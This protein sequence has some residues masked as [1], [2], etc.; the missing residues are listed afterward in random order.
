MKDLFNNFDQFQ[1]CYM[2]T[3]HANLLGALSCSVCNPTGYKDHTDL[4]A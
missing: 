1:P 3:D 2:Q 4:L